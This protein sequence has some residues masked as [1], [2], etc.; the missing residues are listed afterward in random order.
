VEFF[1]RKREH[2]F[3]LPHT[4]HLEIH[5]VVRIDQASPKSLRQDRRAEQIFLVENGGNHGADLLLKLIVFVEKSHQ[6]RK[7]FKKLDKKCMVVFQL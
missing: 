1:R 3:V 6:Y 7:P 5:I 4:K 2:L